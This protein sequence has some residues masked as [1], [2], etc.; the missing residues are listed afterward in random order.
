MNT[1]EN[2]LCLA[3]IREETGNDYT[4]LYYRFL[5]YKKYLNRIKDY[6]E[7]EENIP[8][9]TYKFHK[10][11][12]PDAPW[13][14]IDL[15]DEYA[16]EIY[17]HHPNQK[18]DNFNSENKIKIIES[19]PDE[20]LLQLKRRPK[21]K[22]LK[23][24]PNTYQI[25]TQIRALG[26]LLDGVPERA[27]L[28][29]LFR[30]RDDVNWPDVHNEDI[31]KWYFLNNDEYDGVDRQ[32]EFV[33]KAMG[34]PDFAFLEGPPGSGKTTVLC[35]LVQ[36]MVLKNKRVLICASTHIA[37][38]NLIEKLTNKNPES[39]KKDMI[40]IRMGNDSKKISEK[41]DPWK[42]K[43]FVKNTRTQ[44][45]THLENKSPKTKSS[46]ILEVSLKQTSGGDVMEKIIC[47]CANVVCG[48]TIGILQYPDLKADVQKRRFD[49]MII[50][51]ASKTTFQEFL[52]PAVHA[53][54]WIIVGDT[55]QLAPY[56]DDDE[57]AENIEYAIKSPAYKE[58]CL[59]T[60]MAYKFRNTNVIVTDDEETKSNYQIRCARLNVDY[61]DADDVN[62]P[63]MPKSPQIIVGSAKSISE[64]DL[65]SGNIT[66]RNPEIFQKF[67]K[68]KIK[69]GKKQKFGR[70]AQLKQWS[71]KCSEQQQ[72]SNRESWGKAIGWRLRNNYE[73]LATGV[74][75]DLQ[76]Q[77]F[78]DDIESL[79]PSA[80][81]EDIV[82]EAK[83]NL[84]DIQ[85]IA[86]PSILRSI[87]YGFPKSTENGSDTVIENGMP[88]V[89]FDRRHVLLSKQY[90]MH[91]EIAEFSYRHIYEKNALQTPDMINK[92]RSWSYKAY[93][94]RLVWINAGGTCIDYANQEEADLV[95]SELGNFCKFA[96]NNA[97]PGN[98]TWEVA[99]LTFYKKQE[100]AI[101]KRLRK[102]TGQSGYR[103][104]RMDEKHVS[105][106]LCTVDSFQGHEADI[107][108]LS[109]ANH[110]QTRF[111]NNRNRLNV[112]VTRARY[113][114]VVIGNKKAMSKADPPLKYLANISGQFMVK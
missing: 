107:V 80:I 20:L 31:E 18:L 15:H 109:L 94:H 97:R 32:R 61:Y 5:M 25:T 23:I 112:A 62:K 102:F 59:D 88:Q 9:Y 52:V 11:S 74:D 8:L 90:R 55:K 58:V 91:S 34:T 84:S 12:K 40:V 38:D 95:I 16:Q 49:M 101:R 113:Q 73:S 72:K 50:D 75:K 22:E 108:F 43:N 4:H 37:V 64:L 35:E 56:T 42:Y 79:L 14:T 70:H 93:A 30:D 1:D 39:D 98:I 21:T 69:Q 19:N 27:P 26:S 67:L 17:E 41:A 110:K 45:I 3:N 68:H 10:N 77:E 86:F 63:S 48:T 111:L 28:M 100:E 104:F 106:E 76:L 53:N 92:M 87:Q 33:R 78:P 65:P 82:S 83:N 13:I 114:C 47:D 6:R 24:R 85:R 103:S 96:A 105:I 66:I 57:V 89:D 51:E 71:R 54:R 60:F 29:D 7:R 2:R 99:I 81:D 36:Q 44:M 46:E